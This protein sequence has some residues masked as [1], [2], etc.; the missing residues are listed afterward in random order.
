MT[1]SISRRLAEFVNKLRFE[2]IPTPVVDKAK[3]LTIHFLAGTMEGYSRPGLQKQLRLITENESVAKGGSTVLIE[4]VRVTKAGAGYVHCAL[5]HTFEDTYHMITHPGRSVLP[6]ALAVVEDE[7][8]S[9]KDFIT[10]VVAGYEVQ[11]RLTGEYPPSVMA[12]GFHPG[13]VFSIFGAAV[14]AGKL[15]RLNEEELNSAIALCVSLASGNS[16]GTMS[17]GRIPREAASTRNAMLAVLLAKSGMKGGERCFEDDGGF[18]HSFVGNNKGRLSYVFL[19]PKTV[20]FDEITAELG[21]RWTILDTIHKVYPTGGFNGPHVDVMAKLSADYDIRPANVDRVELTVNWME[22]HTPRAIFPQGPEKPRV[23][24]THYFSA[25]GLVERKYPVGR[26]WIGHADSRVH[27]TPA[28]VLEIMKKT[29]II[30]SR[31]QTLFGPK[32]TVYMKDGKR[33]TAESTGREFMWDWE[34][35]THQLL[36]HPPTLPIPRSQFDDLIAT[37][38]KLDTLRKADELIRV[39]LKQP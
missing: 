25:Y 28:E 22:A 9:G 23:G 33:Y 21:S 35:E 17:G 24:S 6:G 29:R 26:D 10:A 36:E 4:G 32:I 15:M 18:Y 20:S 39:T 2:D 1:T 5:H 38:G 16:S 37:V 11:E 7:G 13:A 8:S 19:G 34:E 31:T 30:S 14:A 12:R 3:A 27:E